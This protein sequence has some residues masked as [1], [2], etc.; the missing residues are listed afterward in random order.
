MGLYPDAAL[1]A[2]TGGI[3]HPD[4]LLLNCQPPDC[5]T[6][7]YSEVAPLRG[8][9]TTRSPRTPGHSLVTPPWHCRSHTSCVPPEM[10]MWTKWCLSTTS[11]NCI[12]NKCRYRPVAKI[13]LDQHYLYVSVRMWCFDLRVLKCATQYLITD[14]KDCLSKL[15]S[16]K[17]I[18]QTGYRQIYSSSL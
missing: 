13:L 16:W 6:G 1:W 5:Q 14:D 17:Y 3:L 9:S 12:N 2:C 7:F 15:I 11:L 18:L 10:Q 8:F 4:P